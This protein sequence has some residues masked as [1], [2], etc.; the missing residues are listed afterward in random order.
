MSQN[1]QI[2]LPLESNPEIFE[3]VLELFQNIK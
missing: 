1:Q 2:W 3:K